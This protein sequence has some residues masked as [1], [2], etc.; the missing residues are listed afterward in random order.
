MF[1]GFERLCAK[2][3][4]RSCEFYVYVKFIRVPNVIK[5][6]IQIKPCVGE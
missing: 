6:M 4:E 3:Q 1:E 2:I 5:S